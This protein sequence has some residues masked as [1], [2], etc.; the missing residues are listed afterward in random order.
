MP[1]LLM[2]HS[3]VLFEFQIGGVRFLYD[4]LIECINRFKTSNGFGCILAHSMGLGK[5]IQVVGF[6]DIFLKHTGAKSV[7]IIVPINT[8]ANWMAEFN[9]WVPDQATLDQH[10]YEGDEIK[11]RPYDIY[12]LNDNYKTTPARSKVV[13]KCF[14]H[15]LLLLS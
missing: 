10:G 13:G 7:L 1:R 14:Y 3:S 9:M 11:P 8:L 4:N 6:T 5:T 12:L 15:T 2:L